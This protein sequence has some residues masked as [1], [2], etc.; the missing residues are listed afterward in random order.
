MMCFTTS[1]EC[2]NASIINP[3]VQLIAF[4]I[5]KNISIVKQ[6]INWEKLTIAIMDK[7]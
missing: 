4:M 2:Q 3:K 7:R 6:N 1:L 5:L